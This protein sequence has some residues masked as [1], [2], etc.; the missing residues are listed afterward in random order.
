MVLGCLAFGPVPSVV[1]AADGASHAVRIVAVCRIS[2]LRESRTHREV[3]RLSE[4]WGLVGLADLLN[5]WDDLDRTSCGGVRGSEA[6]GTAYTRVLL[7]AFEEMRA[8]M[9]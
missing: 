2:A 8:S 3:S 7:E 6:V 1:L 5:L 9:V 4:L